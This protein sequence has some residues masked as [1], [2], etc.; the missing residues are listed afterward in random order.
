MKPYVG[1]I[2]Q[3]RLTSTRLP[4][5]HLLK[6]NGVPVL[7]HL[8]I[9]ARASIADKV[10]IASP[11]S[12]ECCLNEEMFIGSEHDVV[13][14]YYQAAKKYGIDCIVR[15]TAD[16]PFIPVYE[17]NRVIERFLQ[18]DTDYVT[19]ISQDSR[20]GIPDGWDVEAFSFKALE[21]AWLNRDSI[22]EHVTTLIKYDPQFNPIYLQPIKLSLDTEKDYETLKEF[23]RLESNTHIPTKT[24]TQWTGQ[25]RVY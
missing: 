5:K 3:C 4:R 1:V 6:I 20:F 14:R 2:I 17:I 7:E 19:N 10:I 24:E 11:H 16:C 12:P 23:Y 9:R 13:D 8:V 25:T 21:F 18:G 15:L 22:V